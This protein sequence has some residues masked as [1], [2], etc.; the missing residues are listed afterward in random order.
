[1][2][3]KPGPLGALLPDGRHFDFALPFGFPSSEIVKGAQKWSL[4]KRGSRAYRT[5]CWAP[6]NLPDLLSQ[7]IKH[8]YP[9]YAKLTS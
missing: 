8:G 6:E 7:R 1:M 9:Q 2:S 4:G 3:G 5:V